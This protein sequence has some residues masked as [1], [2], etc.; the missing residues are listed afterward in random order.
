MLENKNN[1][2]YRKP[3]GDD[4]GYDPDPVHRVKLPEDEEIFVEEQPFD[5]S[6]IWIMLGLETVAILLPLILTGQAWWVILI[7]AA[8]MLMTLV[9]MSSLKL[10][11]RIDDEGIHYRMSPF[12]W[13]DKTIH[14]AEVDRA[15]VREYNPMLEYGG[16]GIRYGR[17]GKAFNVKGNKGIQVIRKDGKQILIGTQLHDQA[18]KAL[19]K[20]PLMV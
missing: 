17:H 20:R 5:H 15:Y 2:L 3:I 11:S 9:I 13:S 7:G 1:P 19:E 8:V 18:V 4:H 6:W 12:H 10:K 16:W 14:W